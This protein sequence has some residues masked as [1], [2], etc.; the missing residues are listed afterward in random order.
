MNDLQQVLRYRDL[1]HRHWNIVTKIWQVPKSRVLK[2]KRHVVVV[3]RLPPPENFG[4]VL[5]L[6]SCFHRLIIVKM[7]IVLIVICIC[8]AGA[9]ER[10]WV[11]GG[12]GGGCVVLAG[13]A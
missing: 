8:Q 3:S 7:M 2:K 12:L 6:G 9:E 13:G 5:Q 4:L 1:N 10:V 11:F